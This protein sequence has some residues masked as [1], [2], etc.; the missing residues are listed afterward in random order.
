MADERLGMY[1][2]RLPHW[3]L[4][5]ATYFVTWRLRSGLPVLTVGERTELVTV[6]RHFDGQRYALHAFVV[7]DDHI[8]VILRTVMPFRLERIVHS[9]KSYSAHLF[10]QQGRIGRKVWQR[11]YYDRVIRSRSDY[12]EKLSYIVTNPRRRWPGL[13]TYPWVWYD[14]DV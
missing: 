10:R 1:R 4:D 6:L 8:H 5:G 7:M 2:R 9:W 14:P 13:S 3:R 11:E 12:D